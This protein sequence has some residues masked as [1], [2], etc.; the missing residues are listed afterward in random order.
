MQRKE[1]LASRFQTTLDLFAAGEQMMRLKL[2]RE[3]P[4]LTA[5]EVD[6]L[7]TEWLRRR[8]GAEHGDCPGPSRAT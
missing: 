2:Q 6:E 8:P 5:R 4:G 7:L 1:T 3:N